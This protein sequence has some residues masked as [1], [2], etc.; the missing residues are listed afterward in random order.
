MSLEAAILAE[1]IALRNAGGASAS[2]DA[3]Y[4]WRCFKGE[5]Y[6]PTLAGTVPPVYS[7]LSGHPV[8]AFA[9]NNNSSIATYNPFGPVGPDPAKTTM[10][11]QAE[12]YMAP[13]QDVVF[14]FGVTTPSTSGQ[15]ISLNTA[16][17]GVATSFS[18]YGGSG[19]GSLSSA[20]FPQNSW[21]TLTL[22]APGVLAVNGVTIAG[23]RFGSSW[24]TSAALVVSST[25]S[26]PYIRNVYATWK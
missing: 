9:T 25:F 6:P 20:Q 8:L 13:N 14:G 12:F 16:N 19:S 10:L 23:T 21:N 15:L 22:T 11:M 18:I 26:G 3:S 1:V 17:A 2:G 7:R 4:F 24:P 5:N